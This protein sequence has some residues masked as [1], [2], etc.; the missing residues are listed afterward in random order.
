MR[1]HLASQLPLR[2]RLRRDA[3]AVPRRIFASAAAP[4][5]VLEIASAL[6]VA[7]TA[8]VYAALVTLLVATIASG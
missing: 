8:I 4:P 3:P 6:I 2:I 1:A 7:C 5:D